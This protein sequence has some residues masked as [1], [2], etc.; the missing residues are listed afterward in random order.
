MVTIPSPIQ[1]LNDPLFDEKGLEV[2]V[3]REDLIHPVIM[4]NKW[5]KLKYNLLKAKAGGHKTILTMGGAF[6]NHII[7]SAAAA[8]ENGFHSIGIIRGEEL[9]KESNPTLIAA[10]Q[11]GMELIFVSRNQ[12]RNIREDIR[13]FDGFQ[14]DY[15]YLPEGGTNSL[16][17]NGCAELIGELNIDFDYICTPFGTGGT[18][19]GILK[20]LN[21]QKEVLGFP[22]LKGAF[23]NKSFQ[24]LLNVMN[25][26]FNNY[27]LIDQYHFG[28]Y[29][30]VNNELIH[31]INEF[32]EKHDLLL[33]PIYTGKMFFGIMDLIKQGLFKQNI[34]IIL[35]HTGG[36]QGIGGYNLRNR[37]KIL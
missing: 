11:Y 17:I 20:G 35:L 22:V 14:E 23:V 37:N 33:D 36:I 19:A 30:K 27:Q 3:K 10:S 29:G 31:F 34:R 21:G 4:G 15:Y 2:Y 24:E 7:A 13:Q 6:S 9:T 8:S 5:R 25:L 32:T 12:Y 28:G 26:S 1:K 18:M 16:A